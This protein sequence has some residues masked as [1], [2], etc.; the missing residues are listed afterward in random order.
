MTSLPPLVLRAPRILYG[1]AVIYFFLAVGVTVMEMN[2]TMGGDQSSPFSK[3]MMVRTL[4]QASLE[5]L[6]LAANGVVAHILLA[7]WQDGRIGRNGGGD[8]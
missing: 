3:L 6:Y 5:S 1:A 2:V 7:I 4:Y 8:S